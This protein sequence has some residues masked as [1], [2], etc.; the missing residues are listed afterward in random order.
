PRGLLRFLRAVPDLVWALLFVVGFGL[1]R[2]PGALALGVSSAGILGRVYADLFEGVPPGPVVALHAAGASRM[3]VFAAAVWPQ[4]APSVAAYTLYSFECCV[5]AAAVLG[6]VGAGG[7]G[8]EINLSMRLFEYG[9]VLTLLLAFVVVVLLTDTA[10][11]RLRGPHR[12]RSSSTRAT[13]R[14]RSSAPRACWP[15]RPRGW[16]S[17]CF[18]RSPSWSGSCS[19]S[20]PWGSGLSR[21][22]SRWA[23]TRRACSGSSTPRRW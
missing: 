18:D 8:G 1:G 6:F 4:A 7:I 10:S 15:T 3:Q 19:A 5:R 11:R 14:G 9:Q 20:W 2:L 21:A 13:C 23:S 16:C 12:P 22:R 17:R